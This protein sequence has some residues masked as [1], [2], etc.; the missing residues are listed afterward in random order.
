MT[1]FVIV[2]IPNLHIE[3]NL[4]YQLCTFQL[5]R[6]TGSNFTGGG[7]KTPPRYAPGE[8]SPVILVLMSFIFTTSN[9]LYMQYSGQI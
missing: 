7:W 4:S 9:D 5:S 2:D 3:R 6:M 8:K 1:S